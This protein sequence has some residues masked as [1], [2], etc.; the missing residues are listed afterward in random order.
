MSEN[1]FR[2][3][4]PS[5][6]NKV[7]EV[8]TSKSYTNRLLIISSIYPGPV[9]LENYS[10]STDVLNL[11]DCLK[12]IGLKFEITNNSLV[13]HNY[14]PFCETDENA[15]SRGKIVELYSGDG[16]TTNRFLLAL[17]SKGKKRYRVHA[18][19]QMQ[20]R[21]MEEF[22]QI[23]RECHVKVDQLGPNA[24]PVEIQGP[25]EFQKK[26]I[27]INCERTSQFISALSLAFCDTKTQFA[28][29]NLHS[30]K[31]YYVLTE[32]LIK[33]FYFE[34]FKRNLQ[35]QIP[36]DFS[37]ISYPVALGILTGKVVVK[38][39]SFIDMMQPDAI[40][41]KIIKEMGGDY[42]IDIQGLTIEKAPVLKGI[43]WDCSSCPDLVP[44]LSFLCA[45]AQGESRLSNIG[46][47][48]HK[49]SDRIYEIL[50]ILTSFQVPHDYHTE[51]KT[52]IIHGNSPKVSA[53]QVIAVPDH[54]MIMM[55]YLFMR[56]N[57]GGKIY[58]HSHVKKSFE[59]FF[60]V[61]E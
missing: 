28:P 26:K 57:Q 1:D 10:K 23:L 13:I 36:I 58:F 6:L 53:P 47:L 18:E 41:F 20:K 2:E 44:T 38:N 39:C 55:S 14:F 17:L 56:F 54:R 30:S 40:F 16:G 25:L 3:V 29:V 33:V 24:F 31:D 61:M 22:Y 51:S 7:L 12:K 15:D 42:K 11:I 34:H 21:P 52:L 19:G 4:V 32:N 45:Y 9:K 8:P 35:F 46:S 50:K 43:Q 59:N 60:E 37:S 48:Q 5:T 49:E 27:E